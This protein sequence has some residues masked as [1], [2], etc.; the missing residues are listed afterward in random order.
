MP[1]K[2][3][4]TEKLYM[5]EYAKK[6][7]DTLRKYK[8]DYYHKNK[9]KWIKPWDGYHNVYLLQNENYVGVSKNMHNRLS[10]HK[11]TAKRDISDYRILY[12]T[13]DRSEA[14][15]LEALLHDMGYEGRNQTYNR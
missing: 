14:L 5:K 7:A 12:K 15:E 4:E 9:Q 10:H 1:Y 3:K 8:L 2:D 11:W 6:N 13:K